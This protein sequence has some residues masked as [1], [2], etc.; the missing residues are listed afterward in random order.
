[1]G[2][3][4]S[5]GS[6][7]GRIEIPFWRLTPS[8]K[9]DRS[10][11][12]HGRAVAALPQL[13]YRYEPQ[14][15]NSLALDRRGR[16]LTAGTFGVVVKKR[17]PIYKR[18]RGRF[19]AIRLTESGRPDRRFGKRGWTI[20]RFGRRSDAIAKAAVIDARGRL[21]VAGT[22]TRPNL[23]PTGGFALARYLSR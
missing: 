14:S 3:P 11:G 5:A 13:R 12:R 23:E 15:L 7:K 18:I 17:G 2:E 9:R 20:T 4:D 16:I 10:F 19:T 1:M 22:A 6:E 8:G 21:I